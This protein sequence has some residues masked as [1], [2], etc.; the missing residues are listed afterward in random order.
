[1]T[2]A[3]SRSDTITG[4]NAGLTSK[5]LAIGA[6]TSVSSARTE[7]P[8][9]DAA[10]ASAALTEVVPTPPLPRRNT[11]RRRSSSASIAG[12]PEFTVRGIWALPA[13]D[14][15]APGQSAS[16]RT[17]HDEIIV[18][19]PILFQR[20]IERDRHRSCRSVPISIDV[21]KHFLRRQSETVRDR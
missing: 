15:G 6:R 10:S 9:S 8:F 20:L 16:T 12:A 18:A 21:G 4:S 19:Y 7:L 2:I 17:Q 1:R 5:A 13:Q 14:V 11:T 3:K